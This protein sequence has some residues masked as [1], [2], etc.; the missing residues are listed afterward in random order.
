MAG[1]TESTTGAP[2]KAVA[3][4]INPTTTPDTT[5]QCAGATIDHRKETSLPDH[6]ALH[7]TSIATPSPDPTH[8]KKS[9]KAKKERKHAAPQ[10]S[11]DMQRPAAMMASK[12]NATTSTADRLLFQRLA[13]D[14]TNGLMNAGHVNAPTASLD[15]M[16]RLS[17]AAM[18]ST[19][20]TNVTTTT[21]TELTVTMEKETTALPCD[22][23]GRRTPIIS[24]LE[25]L[26]DSD[27]ADSIEYEKSTFDHI[28][29][30]A[31]KISHLLPSY[32]I[33][34]YTARQA[35]LMTASRR[36]SNTFTLG[37]FAAIAAL[38]SLAERHGRVSHMGILDPSYTFFINQTRTAA[39]YYKVK[40]NVA[41]VGGDPL[42]ERKLFPE[43]LKEFTAYCKAHKYGIAFLGASDEFAKYAK[44]Q[45][46]VTMHFGIER[47]L[48]PLT[49]PILLENDGKTGKR[50]ASSNRQLLDP[51]KGG[52]S[53]EVYCPSVARRP[54]L[55]EQLIGVYDAWRD[56]RNQSGLPQAYI[57][58]YDPFALPDLMTYIYTKDRE[59][60][61]N[62]FAALRKL[63]ANNGFHI[64]PCIAAPNA[65]KGITDLLVFS[66]MALLNKAGISYLSFGFEPL[67]ELGE[68]TGMPKSIAK[69]TRIVH[70]EIFQGLRVGGKK[71]YHAK[72]R[73][74]E[75]QESG[76]HL[77]FPEGI[78]G[79]RHM[80]A[81]VH[82]AN[83]SVRQL[84]VTKLKK[85]SVTE[86]VSTSVTVEHKHQE[87][88]SV[89]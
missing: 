26:D 82:H 53:V 58:V 48:N 87:P 62:G 24:A 1:L 31:T 72:F 89:Q 44:Q 67:D 5:K 42:C 27:S 35:S 18:T 63:G 76:L 13:H 21:T 6:D 47:V 71:E 88:G 74:D 55:Q 33:G 54:E 30:Q 64:D 14:M 19:T 20:T 41:V 10:E 37:D 15:L 75:S 43:I 29:T 59:G 78:P 38:E 65:P 46:W 66:A 86:Q 79:V 11:E 68:I 77:I 8:P 12:N 4:T 69:I 51:K 7:G 2:V 84:V 80:T 61:P 81:I 25:G 39:L 34:S 16:N 45:K 23:R 73:P 28:S 22:S 60:K 57:T 52:L 32:L 40:N 85:V 56:H 49:N 17:S 3:G 36:S 83:I 50:M 70:K 9:K